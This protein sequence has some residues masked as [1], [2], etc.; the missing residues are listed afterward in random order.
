MCKYKQR[1]MKDIQDF[2]GCEVIISGDFVKY[3]IDRKYNK[4]ALIRNVTV[5]CGDEYKKL[6]H[7]WVKASLVKNGNVKFKATCNAYQR[8]NG[9]WDYGFTNEVSLI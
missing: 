8:T 7:F 6:D 1:K 5:E 3:S 9:S 2:Y 4:V